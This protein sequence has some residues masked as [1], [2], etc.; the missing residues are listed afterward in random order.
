MN[1]AL[2]SVSLIFLL[3]FISISQIIDFGEFENESIQKEGFQKF[4]EFIGDSR[5]VIIG[6]QEHGIGT[7]Y[8]NFNFLSQFL[9]EEMDFDIIIQEYCF[10][11]FYK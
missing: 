3:P 4:K 7:H 10:F 8:Q 9:H 11:E 5:I 2:I 6:E 1:K